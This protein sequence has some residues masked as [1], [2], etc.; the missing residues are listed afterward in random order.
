M[1]HDA[2]RCELRLLL[3]GFCLTQHGHVLGVGIIELDRLGLSLFAALVLDIC[4]LAPIPEEHAATVPS[5]FE[6]VAIVVSLEYLS[7][8]DFDFDGPH[9]V[10]LPLI[11]LPL[12]AVD[13]PVGRQ[14]EHA[15]PLPLISLPLAAVDGSWPLDPIFYAKPLPLVLSP[16]TAIYGAIGVVV[17]AVPLPFPPTKLAAINVTVGPHMYTDSMHVVLLVPA[18]VETVSEV[19]ALKNALACELACVDE[20]CIRVATVVQ[21]VLHPCASKL[22]VQAAQS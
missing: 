18:V 15:V 1:R 19:P 9:A 11:F 13:L 8:F 12:A 14:H 2:Y 3:G 21:G 10:P 17:N 22:Q 6:E 20:P 4:P 16:L 5:V 7:S